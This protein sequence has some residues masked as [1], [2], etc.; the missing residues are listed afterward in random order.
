MIQTIIVRQ[1]SKVNAE[2]IVLNNDMESSSFR[3]IK[4]FNIRSYKN[5]YGFF[6]WGNSIYKSLSI[7]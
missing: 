6:F 3:M 5:T 7:L 4:F 1:T 2:R